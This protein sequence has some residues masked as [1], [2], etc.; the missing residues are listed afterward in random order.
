MLIAIDIGNSSINIGYFTDTGLLTQKL[1]T[2]PS[3]RPEE[4]RLILN[5]FLSQNLS[6]KKDIRGI[7]SSV[8]LGRSGLLKAAL[9]GVADAENPEV[10]LV[11]HEMKT[12]LNYRINQPWTLGTDRIAGAAGACGLYNAPVAVVDCGTA[13]TITVVDRDLNILGGSIMP[14]L[15][16]MNDALGSGTSR[17]DSTVLNKP[18]SALGKDTGGCILSGLFYGTAGAV[19][20]ILS[21]IGNET[22][23]SFTVVI[24]G[25]YGQMLSGLIRVE[26]KLRPNLVLEGL[27]IL[28]DKN[29][30]S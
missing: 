27:K 8:V 5:D 2:H 15:G 19:E 9:T 17:L 16:L 26:H 3:L 6:D 4:Y 11:S 13:T 12:G 28:Y 23:E 7:I 29:R 25:G 10:L 30:H 14:G 24:T 22:K 18:G 20:R 21:E 1:P